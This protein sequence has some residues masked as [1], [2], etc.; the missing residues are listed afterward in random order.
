MREVLRR[1]HYSPRTE[2]SY[3]D[4][5]SR[6]VRFHRGRAPVEMG[7]REITAFLTHLA[8]DLRVG[9]STQRQAV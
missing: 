6:F 2:K 4:W 1:K 5:M 3:I 9:V 8:V 7:A